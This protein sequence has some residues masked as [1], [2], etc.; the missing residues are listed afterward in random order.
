M[1]TD[2]IF[3]FKDI[4]FKEFGF[5]ADCKAKFRFYTQM[6]KDIWVI[7]KDLKSMDKEYYI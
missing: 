4:F 6:V 2:N 5:K 1:E 3:L 7:L